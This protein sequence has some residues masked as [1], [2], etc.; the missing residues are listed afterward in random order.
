M[1]SF[2]FDIVRGTVEICKVKRIFALTLL[3]LLQANS[4]KVNQKI[5]VRIAKT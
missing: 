3:A 4:A 5:L 2:P 1:M